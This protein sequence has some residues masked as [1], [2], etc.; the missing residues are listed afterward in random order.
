MPSSPTIVD[1]ERSLFPFF[2]FNK[3]QPAS[4][5][6]ESVDAMVKSDT[7]VILG[8]LFLTSLMIQ[9]TAMLVFTNRRVITISGRPPFLIIIGR[10]FSN[11][12]DKIPLIGLIVEL[13]GE[14]INFLLGGII[15]KSYAKV[16]KRLLEI[17]DEKVLRA[18][19]SM[20]YRKFVRP[21]SGISIRDRFFS[22]LRQSFH[23]VSLRFL[24]IDNPRKVLSAV[25]DSAEWELPDRQAIGKISSA[26][27]LLEPH[28]AAFGVSVFEKPN[29]VG[30]NWPL[31]FGLRGRGWTVH[32][33]T[34]I[35]LTLAVL[36]V[37]LLF[38]NRD[39]EVFTGVLL[40]I[41]SVESY[42]HGRSL[43]RVFLMVFLYLALIFQFLSGAG[44]FD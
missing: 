39:I 13:I 41:G 35:S 44:V 3:I 14:L 29:E 24:P 10:L 4:T 9:R 5:D 21:S 43:G 17:P 33:G 27:T 23:T 25:L 20:S 37:L 6:E 7:E 15:R 40:L 1:E 42:V 2:Q 32:L 12:A 30:I 31:S 22:I 26:L 11:V 16:A 8:K 34:A 18:K 36:G 28:L 19:S 38:S